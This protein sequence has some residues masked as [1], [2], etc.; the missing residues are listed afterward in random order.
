MT[1]R[2]I[3]GQEHSFSFDEVV[4]TLEWFGRKYCE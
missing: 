1:L 2:D 4:E 3:D